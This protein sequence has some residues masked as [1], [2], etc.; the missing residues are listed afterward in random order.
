MQV[1]LKWEVISDIKTNEQ[2]VMCGVFKTTI[3]IYKTLSDTNILNGEPFLIY[4]WVSKY[5]M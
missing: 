2:Y 5:G 3:K 1:V 4:R